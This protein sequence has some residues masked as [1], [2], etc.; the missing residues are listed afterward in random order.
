MDMNADGGGG[1]GI[2]ALP[3]DIF[4]EVLRRLRV[5]SLARLVASFV[6]NPTTERWALLPPPPTWWPHGH[7]GLFLA[8]DPAVSLEYEV[9]LLPVPPPR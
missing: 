2:D 1:G 6:C 3:G 8:F 5:H 9:L 7:K 4:I